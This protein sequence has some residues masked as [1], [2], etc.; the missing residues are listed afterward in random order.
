MEWENLKPEEATWEDANFMKR[1][2]PDFFSSTIKAWFPRFEKK[3]WFPHRYTEVK[4]VLQR[5]ALSAESY[6][7]S[8]M[9]FS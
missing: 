4:Y 8:V 7:A 1:V 6:S 2:F 5:E 3:T 9:L